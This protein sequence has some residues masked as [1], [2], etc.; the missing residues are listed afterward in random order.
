MMDSLQG[1]AV[2]LGVQMAACLLEDDVLR[3]C[4]EKSSRV[5]QRTAYR[6]G[7]QPGF[8]ILNGQK[9][10]MGGFWICRYLAVEGSG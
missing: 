10:A 5:V 1:F 6:H 3:L 2:E 7:N 8:V 9:V 4:G